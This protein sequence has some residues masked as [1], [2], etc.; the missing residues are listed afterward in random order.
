MAVTE[1]FFKPDRLS[2]YTLHLDGTDEPND[3]H[4]PPI[5]DESLETIN[6]PGILS[7]DATRY[8]IEN[9]GLTKL[10]LRKVMIPSYNEDNSSEKNPFSSAMNL[11]LVTV[12]LIQNLKAA[13]LHCRLRN[14][15]LQ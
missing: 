2:V 15:T 10:N 7:K 8:V 6:K 14:P 9:K 11:Y 13:I 5:P 1:A 4:L 12:I 3:T